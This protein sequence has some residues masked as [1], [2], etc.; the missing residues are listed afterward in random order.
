MSSGIPKTM[1]AAV[2]TGAQKPLEI[3]EIPVPEPQTGEVLIKVHACGVCHSDHHVL[4]GDMGPPGIQLLGHEFIGTVVKTTKGEKKWKV[5]DRVGGPWHGGHDLSCRACNRGLFQMCENKAINGVTRNGG[6]GE[7][8]TLRTESAV[9]IPANMDPAEVAPLLCAGV[10]VFNGIRQLN[11][12]SGE[13]V[14]VQGLGGLGHLAIQ[15]ARKM[16]YRTVALSR[17]SAKK[18]FAMKLGATDYIDTE[19]GDVAAELQKLGGAACIV[20]T[21]PNPDVITPLIGGLDNKGKLLLFT[22]IGPVPVNTVDMVLKGLSVHGWPSGHALD[23]EE[24]I[25]FAEKQGVKCM[26]EKFPLAKANEAMEHMMSGK[27]RFRAVLTMD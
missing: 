26:I 22:A 19:A 27:V 4:N 8:A 2:L 5:G 13:I 17:G 6:Y 3:K 16:G 21:A 1:K 12:L 18:D 14:A 10:T 20:V 15:Y 11:I 24:A 25:A 9:R 7:Y 23:S